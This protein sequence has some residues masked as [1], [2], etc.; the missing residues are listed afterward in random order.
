MKSDSYHIGLACIF[1]EALIGLM[2]ASLSVAAG[3]PQPDHTMIIMLENQTYSG[4]VGS[5]NAPYIDSLLPHA[6]NFTDMQAVTDPSQPNSILF[7]SG[8]SNGCFSNDP[9]T[10]YAD[11]A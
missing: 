5:S 10:P 11:P 8:E 6:A 2:R 3:I 1:L 7:C 9:I 4:I